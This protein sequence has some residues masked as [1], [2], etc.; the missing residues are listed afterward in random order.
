MQECPLANIAI[1]NAIKGTVQ[2]LTERHI[3]GLEEGHRLSSQRLFM[4]LAA[5]IRDGEHAVIDD[6]V[7]L[8]CLGMDEASLTA[9]DVWRHLIGRL[10]GLTA[11]HAQC[12]NLILE[13]GTLASRMK[14]TVGEVTSDSLKALCHTLCHCLQTGQM[15]QR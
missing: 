8:R 1:V 7:Y 2:N 6:P 9:G 14:Q 3:G 4:I 15:L 11:D 12:L 10:D 5:G 13:Q